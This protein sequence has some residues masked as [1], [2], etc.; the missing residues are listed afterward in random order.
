MNITEQSINGVTV[1]RADGRID[2]GNATEFE[3]ALVEALGSGSTRLVVDMEKLTYIS[4]AGLRSLL[5][6]AKKARPGG[7][8]IA[9]SAMAPHIREV[10]DLSGFSSLFEIHGDAGAAVSALGG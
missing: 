2:S 6:A 1:L 7:G 3:N 5:I 8:R 4:S 9:L 10:F